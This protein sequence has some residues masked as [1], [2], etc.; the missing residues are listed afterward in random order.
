MAAAA[1]ESETGNYYLIAPIAISSLGILPDRS[2]IGASVSRAAGR[3][4]IAERL[5]LRNPESG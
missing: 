1:C 3:K 5:R 2:K 4:F